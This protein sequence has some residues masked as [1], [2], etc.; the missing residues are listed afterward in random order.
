MQFCIFTVQMYK[1]MELTRQELIRLLNA[2]GSEAEA[3]RA[4]ADGC[5]RQWV[6]NKVY[7]R[8][9]IE[10]S[11]VCRKNCLYC[12]IRKEN[13]AVVRYTLS[14]DE[15][16]AATRTAWREGYG[17]VVLQGGESVSPAHTATIEGLIR[18]INTLSAGELGITLSLGEQTEETYRRWF[19]AGAHRYLLR[20]ESSGEGLYRSIHP[21]DALHRYDSRREAL[22]A[23]RRV[24]YQVGTGVMIGL[25][26]QTLENLADD[27]LFMRQ[28]DIDMCGMGPYLEH[29]QTPLYTRR[30]EL[31]LPE[32]RLAVA[33]NMV[34]LLRILMPQ[35]NIA[36]TTALQAIDPAGREKAL[37]AGANVVMP[38]LTP[39]RYKAD[40]KLYE[41]K[42][43]TEWPDIPEG[44]IGYGC[45][46]DSVH[47]QQRTV[48]K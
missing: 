40:Y 4:R 5:R 41:N 13:T 26:G 34:A 12:G 46:G 11:N 37:R 45:R 31:W 38:N 1:K 8:G 30:A 33:L 48:G 24:G 28:Q 16:V 15:V 17:S 20:I 9:L 47:F 39:A 42:P 10:Y 2:E 14:E 23:L 44:E 32:K 29:A 35:I 19:E 21:A 36:A 18:R 6:G 7:L 27:L 43:V 25:P 3:L 22:R